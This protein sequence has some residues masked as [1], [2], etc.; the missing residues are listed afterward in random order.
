[1][2]HYQQKEENYAKW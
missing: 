2:T 1:M